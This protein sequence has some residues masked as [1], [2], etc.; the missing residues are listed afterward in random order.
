MAY[1]VI[2]KIPV[3]LTLDKL[4]TLRNYVLA[5][6]DPV[7]RIAS[8]IS[9]SPENIETKELM[10]NYIK[11]EY[12][13]DKDKFFEDW[14][15]FDLSHKEAKENMWD[16]LYDYSIYT[17]NCFLSDIRDQIEKIHQDFI[18]KNFT[19][20]MGKVFAV[21]F[22]IRHENNILSKLFYNRQHYMKII[23]D[24]DKVLKITG[25]LDDF[26]IFTSS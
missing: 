14:V 16:L 5:D 20:P 21:N 4:K 12:D 18:G 11:Q 26:Y 23:I 6:K 8:M 15:K 19:Y 24:V 3:F 25:K 10:F 9:D 17:S 13:K 1:Y 22:K 2:N 7:Y